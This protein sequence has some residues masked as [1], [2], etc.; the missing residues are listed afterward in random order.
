M[1]MKKQLLTLVMLIVVVGMGRAQDKL[2]KINEDSFE[3][4]AERAA[5]DRNLDPLMADWAK[6][7]FNKYC[8]DKKNIVSFT[9]ADYKA[10]TDSIAI[11]YI[12]K[13]NNLD[14]DQ[15]KT[16][17]QI[18]DLQSQLE[19]QVQR[20][21]ALDS[22]VKAQQEE[23]AKLQADAQKLDDEKSQF[24][25]EKDELN[26]AM[27]DLSKDYE[28]LEKE[29]N[30]LKRQNDSLLVVLGQQNKE[31]A[32]LNSSIG[33]YET[34]IR[35]TKDTINRIYEA[36]KNISVMAMKTDDLK[37]ANEAFTSMAS[38]LQIDKNRNSY[39]D[40]QE[41]IN[42]MANWQTLGKALNDGIEYMKGKYVEKTR[43]DCLNAIQSAMYK[44]NLSVSQQSES[45]TIVNALTNQIEV[46]RKF[47]V[48]MNDLINNTYLLETSKDASKVLDKI[49][50][51]EADLRGKLCDYHVMHN[52]AIYAMRDLFTKAEDDFSYKKLNTMKGFE[53]AINDIKAIYQ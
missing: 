26:R 6:G 4:Y 17:K 29:R 47:T 27:E 34:A 32:K 40:L 16:E 37:R 15:G 36:N 13:L 21:D 11:F 22:I 38:L 43:Q 19:E 25:S 48:L 14:I 24:D 49:N 9:E 5:K 39:N 45:Q 28:A 10:L 42:D 3:K 52:K 53:N 18:A 23:L 51:M 12:P 20:A 31:V 2:V 33:S 7:V 30:D 1:T 35:N 44:A 41:K 8:G 50:K 46:Q